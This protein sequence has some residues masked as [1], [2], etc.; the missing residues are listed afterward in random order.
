MSDSVRRDSPYSLESCRHDIPISLRKRTARTSPSWQ[1]VKFLKSFIMSKFFA[2]MVH[3][4]EANLLIFHL[5]GILH[6]AAAD[7]R[8][9]K[10]PHHGWDAI[11]LKQPRSGYD[12]K[13]FDM[14][15][16]NALLTND[17]VSQQFESIRVYWGKKDLE[18]RG[19]VGIFAASISSLRNSR[20]G[21]QPL[22]FVL[23]KSTLHFEPQNIAHRS[24]GELFYYSG[25]VMLYCTCSCVERCNPTISFTLSNARIW[26]IF[27]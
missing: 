2:S 16:C 17:V 7:S 6:R 4:I 14:G 25:T 24:D 12:Y 26:S 23:I 19:K 5:T 22:C 8:T 27:S 21:R 20:K 18:G 11:Q 9:K 3:S 13:V 1:S 10:A 15:K